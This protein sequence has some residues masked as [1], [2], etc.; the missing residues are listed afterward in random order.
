MVILKNINKIN[1]IITCEYYPEGKDDKGVGNITYDYVKNEVLEKKVVPDYDDY[2]E[3]YFNYALKR[4]KRM[5]S[6]GK[7][8]DDNYERETVAYWY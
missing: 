3:V 1:S 4:L 6:M 7:F 8:E 5:T 2:I